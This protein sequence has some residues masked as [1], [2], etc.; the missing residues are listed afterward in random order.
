MFQSP[1]EPSYH[2]KPLH[3]WLAQLDAKSSRDGVSE[4]AVAVRTMGTNTLPVLAG[5]LVARDPDWKRWLT[6]Q[7]WLPVQLHT[8]DQ[9]IRRAS[10]GLA[11]LR[12]Q[13]IPT[14]EKLL[15]N[16]QTTSQAAIALGRMAPVGATSLSKGLSSADWNVRFWCGFVLSSVGT[17]NQ[18]VGYESR[19]AETARIAIPALI[20]CL[21]DTNVVVA[22][23][24]ARALANLN[25]ELDTVLPA[26]AFAST[27][28]AFD[29]SVRASASNAFVALKSR[30][31]LR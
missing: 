23:V 17:W 2:G 7:R 20:I 4:A 1:A 5:M 6:Q 15:T 18:E 25:E 14:L 9:T 31:E 12:E 10:Y 27:N 26:L 19:V 29:P 21:R 24:A 3:F 22:Q 11:C 8:S 30:R 13:A 16:S 28:T